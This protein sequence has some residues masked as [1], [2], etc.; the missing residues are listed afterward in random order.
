MDIFDFYNGF[1]KLKTFMLLETIGEIVLEYEDFVLFLQQKQLSAGVNSDDNAV[2]V[3][4]NFTQYISENY[5]EY[6]TVKP[7]KP[8]IAG[9]KYNFEWSGKYFKG[10]FIKVYA[11]EKFEIEIDSKVPYSKD[12]EKKYKNLLGFI[13]KNETE[14][15]EFLEIKVV[16]KINKTIG[17]V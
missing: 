5:Q 3:Y 17:N 11:N 2:G 4:T 8:K 14:F 7:I 12:I 16:E 6:G 13:D 1:A 15:N 9:E 10:M